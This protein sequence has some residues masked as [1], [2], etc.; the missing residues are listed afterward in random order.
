MEKQDKF[1]IKSIAFITLISFII[2]LTLWLIYNDLP[3]ENKTRIQKE[4]KFKKIK[5]SNLTEL[6][7]NKR[8][9]YEQLANAK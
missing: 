5:D 2:T 9:F 7:S 4:Y 8:L 1:V 3:T 6:T